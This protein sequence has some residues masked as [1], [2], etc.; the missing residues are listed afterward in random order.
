[1]DATVEL[2]CELIRCRSVTPDDG[3]CQEII[4]GRLAAAGFEVENLRF[5]EVDNLWA[6]YGDA[7][8]TLCLLGHTDVVP[9][10]PLED[11]QSD[12]FEPRID[13][14]KLYGRGA[15]DMKSSVAAMVTAA[16]RYAAV[17]TP[18]D[19][20]LA[21]LLTSDEEGP[22]IHGV[23]RVMEVFGERGTRIDWCLVGEPSCQTALGDTVKHGRRGSL[24]GRIRLRGQQGH[25]DYPTLAENALHHLLRIVT[26]LVDHDWGPGDADF[27]PSSFQISN[28]NAG[29]GADNVIPGVA[30]V[31]FNIR[32]N[33]GLSR[34]AI[35]Q[36]VSTA[37]ESAGFAP[38]DTRLEL[39]WHHSGDPFITREGPLLDALEQS[40]QAVCGSRPDRST[41]GGT[42]DGRFVAPAG[43]QVA[44]F[45]P[46][47]A[48]IHKV[49][50]HVRVDDLPRLS[51]VYEQTI[52]RLL[53]G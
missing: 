20:R 7:G 42:S 15:A 13:D 31:C 34:E 19:G 43:A 4:G 5:G 18:E 17:H 24:T 49:D 35:K 21:I 25:V 3:G 41:A 48:S 22:G 37:C 23:R 32:Y 45:G 27:P 11:W 9:P 26:P 28:L 16:E 8:P 1:M 38:G 30:D 33:P 39:D 51:E 50:E 36:V 40:I 46:L 52:S 14:G 6:V 12:P 44:E 29:T 2:A 10:G 47:N 53:V